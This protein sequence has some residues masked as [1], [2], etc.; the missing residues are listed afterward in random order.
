[1]WKMVGDFVVGASR[2]HKVKEMPS[3]KHAI[4]VDRTNES[5][6]DQ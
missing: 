5:G 4:T 3:F 6:I 2:G 1:M